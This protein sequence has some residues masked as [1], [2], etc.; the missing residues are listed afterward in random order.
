MSSVVEMSEVDPEGEPPRSSSRDQRFAAW[1]DHDYP[2]VVGVAL[3]VLDR[4]ARWM[5]S[6]EVAEDLATEAFSRLRWSRRRGDAATTAV[7]QR[8]LDGCLDALV[9]HPGAVPVHPDVLGL[10]DDGYGDGLLSLAEL[11]EALSTMR[12]ADRH[13]GLLSLAAGYSP[14]ETSALLQRPLDDVLA[15]L[16]RVGTRLGDAR[17][18]GLTEAPQ[19]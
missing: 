13:V 8:T 12:T 17:R 18:L 5:S 10:D 15:R 16:A 2:R 9:G 4:D 11:Q 19:P 14:S 7:L 6:R 3:R 1:F